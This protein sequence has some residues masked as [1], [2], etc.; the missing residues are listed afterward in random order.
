[1]AVEILSLLILLALLM[2]LNLK[3]E[4]K[5]EG[6]EKEDGDDEV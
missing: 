4:E 2:C 6:A 1:M 3:V 5:N